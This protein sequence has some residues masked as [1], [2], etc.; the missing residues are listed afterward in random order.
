MQNCPSPVIRFPRERV[1]FAVDFVPVES[2]AFRDFPDTYVEDWIE[3]LKQVELMD[4]DVLA[5]GH[6]SLGRK[7]HVRRFREY[8]Q[9]LHGA[10]LRYVGEG[11]PEE[12]K[13]LIKLPKYE[14]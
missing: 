14:K 10:V 2:V 3:S 6:G 11:N 12:M 5:P 13:T 7:E 4:F 1:L 9:D 8:M